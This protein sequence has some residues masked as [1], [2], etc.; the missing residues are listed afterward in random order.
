MVPGL[1]GKEGG[2]PALTGAPEKWRMQGSS[3]RQ[4]RRDYT[5]E[6]S[7]RIWLPAPSNQVGPSLR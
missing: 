6:T 4:G 1:A 3:S 2:A 5:T 7:V